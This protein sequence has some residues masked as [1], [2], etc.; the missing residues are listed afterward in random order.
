MRS[1][2]NNLSNPLKSNIIF[3]KRR[4]LKV[5]IFISR[6]KTKVSLI[7]NNFK[8]SNHPTSN[9]SPQSTNKHPSTSLNYTS[10]K[11]SNKR[12]PQ[13]PPK[14]GRRQW[15]ELSKNNTPIFLTPR[16]KRLT[17]LTFSRWHSVGI[18]LTLCWLSPFTSFSQHRKRQSRSEGLH[19]SDY[20]FSNSH[21][22]ASPL[23]LW[24]NPGKW[25]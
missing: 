2:T 21:A 6:I 20:F 25:G 12:C 17:N 15:S 9:I 22:L 16:K 19:F 3:Y 23:I 13:R 24:H 18:S 4:K 7:P 1:N 5:K 8:V 11:L 10:N 14:R